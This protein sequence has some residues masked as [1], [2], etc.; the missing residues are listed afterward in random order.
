MIQYICSTWKKVNC[1][2]DW[3]LTRSYQNVVCTFC[4]FRFQ[5]RVDENRYHSLWDQNN[6]WTDSRGRVVWRGGCKTQEDLTFANHIY[7]NWKPKKL[8]F[9]PNVRVEANTLIVAF[10][11]KCRDWKQ[12]L[13]YVVII[14]IF[15]FYQ[16]N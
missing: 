16:Y 5:H 2:A 7:T 4:L 1:F 9:C 13:S 15:L 11:I 8:R 14:F 6:T 10:G 12:K 3:H